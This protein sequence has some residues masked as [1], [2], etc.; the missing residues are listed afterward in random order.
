MKEN[1]S[2]I[3]KLGVYCRVSSRKQIDN[4]SLNNQKERGINY[5]EEN[6]FEYEVFSDAIS[7]NKV[8]RDGLDELFIKIGNGQLDG[9]VLYEWD[10]LN[11]ES[12]QLLLE[13]EEL[14]KLTNCI[15]IVDNK[16]RDIYKNLNDRI[17]YEFKN[18]LS[19][20]E[21]IT[22]TKRVGQGIEAFMERGDVFFGISKFG[23][24]RVGK[25][26]TL[27]VEI[28]E[29][30]AEIVREI[31]RVF[32]LE[33]INTIN[34]VRKRIN[35]KYNKEYLSKFISERLRYEGYC[36]VTKQKYKG[37]EYDLLLPKII[38]EDLFNKTQIKLEKVISKNRGREKEIQILKGLIYCKDCGSRLYQKGNKNSK[39]GVWQKWYQCKMYYK[40]QYEK[41][42]IKW[43]SGMRC[44]KSYKGNYINKDLFEDIVWESLFYFLSKSKDLKEELGKKY[45]DE[46]KIK[47]SS[48]GKK[49]YYSGLID[50]IE[51]KKFKLYNEK[52]EGKINQKE[53]DSFSKRFN[54]EIE[55]HNIRISELEGNIKN[56][57]KV[58]DIDFESINELVKRD[59]ELKYSLN[60]KKD[61][62]RLL[63]KYINKLYLKRLG[64]QEYKLI[65]DLKFNLEDNSNAAEVVVDKD[66]NSYIKKLKIWH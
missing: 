10:R 24:K 23:Y 15:V 60:S 18:A 40:P 59:L 12:K 58:A 31:Y 56:Y 29:E 26:K 39:S 57:N 20:I 64:D 17:E 34:D 46:L 21:R 43:E 22:L 35:K 13:F 53:F 65:F 1:L 5:C 50:E 62:I 52:L 55:K 47:D 38:E 41:D 14:V 2:K 9:I 63:D 7:G 54:E 16:V 45:K 4:S 19:G 3:R 36:K 11:R 42:I 33:S 28:N 48:I 8:N 32:N 30:E 49:K 51:D 61:K 25:K 44:D 66:K 6:G 27:R 37:K